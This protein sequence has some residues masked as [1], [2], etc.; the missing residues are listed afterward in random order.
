MNAN[1]TNPKSRK[2]RKTAPQ[3]AAAPEPEAEVQTPAE[4]ARE[5]YEAANEALEA[6]KTRHA[7]A[8]EALRLAKLAVLETG[9]T[10]AR[11]ERPAMTCLDAAFK[12][13]QGYCAGVARTTKELVKEMRETGLWKPTTGVT[14]WA[15][16][17]AELHRNIAKH[18][19]ASR[20]A[21]GEKGGTFCLNPALNPEG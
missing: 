10:A 5:A 7:E 21:R 11:A 20:F 2:P 15:T 13:L 14:P 4:A 17:Y 12:V 8:C 6:A 19:A 1:A 9:K 3:A 18:G 16:L